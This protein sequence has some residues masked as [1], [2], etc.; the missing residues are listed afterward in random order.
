MGGLHE[1][2]LSLVQRAAAENDVVCVS[3]FVN[4]LQFGEALDFDSYPRDFEG[5]C[6]LLASAGAHMAFTGT[7]EEFFPGRLDSS[8]ALR[9]E[10]YEDPGPCA[11]GL[12]GDFRLGHF[13]GVA[14]IVHR[15]F[16]VG[17]PDRAYFG[18]K[19]FQQSLVVSDVAKRMGNLEV[20][21]CET[22]RE[23][24]G[25]ARSSRN[26]RLSIEDWGCAHFLSRALYA[27]RAQWN[28][29][30]RSP[31]RLSALMGAILELGKAQGLDV[32]YATVRDPE[33]W[34]GTEPE[35]PLTRGVALVAARVGEVRLIDNMV[36]GR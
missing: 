32:E 1:G 28:L 36:L 7:L 4:P 23:H 30:E 13:E 8:G 15:L 29:G 16:E 2:H 10:E 19:D 12:E 31:Q 25:L 6:D 35:V 22:L 9:P 34:S 18:A 17:L 26:T 20:V 33:A 21:V 11:A 27:V 3:I 24:S 5:D 14:T